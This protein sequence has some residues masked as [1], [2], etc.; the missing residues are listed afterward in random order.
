MLEPMNSKMFCRSLIQDH[1]FFPPRLCNFKSEVDTGF[2]SKI[3]NSWLVMDFD[4]IE[5]LIVALGENAA[6]RT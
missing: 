1:A 6:F 5:D 4:M 3:N 2:N